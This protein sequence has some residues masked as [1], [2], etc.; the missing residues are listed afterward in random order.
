[1][2]GALNDPEGDP[3]IDPAGLALNVHA[4]L[5]ETYYSQLYVRG[6]VSDLEAKKIETVKQ[7]LLCYRLLLA[8][9]NFQECHTT[10]RTGNYDA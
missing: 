7:A 1:L 4:D 8:S 5:L 10:E 3:D 6:E 9:R 2:H